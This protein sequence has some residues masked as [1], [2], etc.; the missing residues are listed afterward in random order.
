MVIKLQH[1]VL[2]KIKTNTNFVLRAFSLIELLA[3]IS[4]IGILSVVSVTSY[5]SHNIRTAIAALIPLADAAKN[6]VEDEHNQGVVFGASSGDTVYVASNIADKPY[7]L[8]DIVRVNYGCVNLNIDLAALGLDNTKQLTLVWCPTIDNRAVEWRC[9]YDPDS[10]ADYISYLP[11]NC[12][13]DISAFVD[14]TF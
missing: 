12:Q 14:S 11:A 4:I 8:E 9:G 7:A 6:S 10:Y 1:K 5:R 3:V 2:V 13:N